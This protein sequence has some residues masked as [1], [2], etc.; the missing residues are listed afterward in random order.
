MIY[1]IIIVHSNIPEA[2]MNILADLGN[3]KEL[4]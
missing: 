1:T 4:W 2:I 3:K